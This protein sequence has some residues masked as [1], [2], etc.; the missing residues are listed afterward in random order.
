MTKIRATASVGVLLAILFLPYWAYIPALTAAM[1]VFPFFWE[2]IVLA[3]LIDMLYGRGIG[4]LS[5]LLSPM[6][7][8]ATLFLI[9]LVPVR[10]RLRI[11]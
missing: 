10:E 1:I 7:F 11:A 9:A 3:Y 4:T 2:G 8:A 6:A 5:E